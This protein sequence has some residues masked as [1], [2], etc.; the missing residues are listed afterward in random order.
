MLW[1][2]YVGEPSKTAIVDLKI[3]GTKTMIRIAVDRMVQ[4]STG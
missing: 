2:L 4:D 1:L 3:K